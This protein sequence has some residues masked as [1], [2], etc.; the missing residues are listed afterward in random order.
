MSSFTINNLNAGSLQS[1]TTTPGKTLLAW[2]GTTGATTLR[3]VWLTEIEWGA[4]DVPNATDCNI[5]LTIGR[6]TADGTGSALTPRLTD[7]GGGD[8]AALASY[9]A[10]YSAEPTVTASSAVFGKPINQRASDKQW[11][12]DKATCPIT[13]AVNLQGWAVR[14]F[15]PN[16]ASTV[17]ANAHVEE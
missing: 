14:A 12:R 7:D 1:I 3:R 2:W 6:F 15:S 13:A 17:I 5:T 11:W 4:N 9:K 10:N 8:A 16:Y